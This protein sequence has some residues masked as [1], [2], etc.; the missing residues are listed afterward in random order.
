MKL[1]DRLPR[2]IRVRHYSIRTERTYIDRVK[3]FILF[4]NNR[5]PAHTVPALPRRPHMRKR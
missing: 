5:H 2:E 4:H 3:R 1:L